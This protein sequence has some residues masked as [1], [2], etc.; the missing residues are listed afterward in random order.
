TGG[1]RGREERQAQ[2]RMRRCSSAAHPRLRHPPLK[3]GDPGVS[4]KGRRPLD[5]L[6]L[7]PYIILGI[8]TK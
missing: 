2:G 7:L 4:Y 1:E 5:F 8:L 3:G 6:F